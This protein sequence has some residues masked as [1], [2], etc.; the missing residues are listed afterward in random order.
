MLGRMHEVPALRH[1]LPFVRQTYARESTYWW[2]DEAV[3][4][5]V[6]QHE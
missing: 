3:R 2:A 5:R 4:H 6:R 1:L